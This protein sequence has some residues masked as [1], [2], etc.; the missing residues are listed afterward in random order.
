VLQGEPL[1]VVQDGKLIE[2]NLK[3]ERLTI[4][5]V[6]EEARGNEIESL[7]EIKFAVVEAGGTVSFLKK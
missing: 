5:D 3:E 6:M 2:R 4:D 7:D 1:I